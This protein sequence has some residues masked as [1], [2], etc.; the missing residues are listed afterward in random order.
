MTG[1]DR[2]PPPAIPE[3]LPLQLDGDV[4]PR[5]LVNPLPIAT[6]SGQSRINGIDALETALTRKLI[7]IGTRAGNAIECD[8]PL[9]VIPKDPDEPLV[10][11]P[12]PDQGTPSMNKPTLSRK[13][14]DKFPVQMPRILDVSDQVQKQREQDQKDR[15]GQHDRS[16]NH[17]PVLEKPLDL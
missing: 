7:E 15:Q 10:P 2:N 16:G 13:L 14:P 3:S 11:L 12:E 8:E 5:Y 6:R 9:L 1:D 17:V 4:R